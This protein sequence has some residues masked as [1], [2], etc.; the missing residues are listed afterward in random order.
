MPLLKRPARIAGRG[1][2]AQ[3][4]ATTAASV[5]YCSVF[6]FSSWPADS[7]RMPRRPP[8]RSS[9]GRRRTQNA[10]AH[11]AGNVALAISEVHLGALIHA[12]A[13]F[14][15]PS[16]SLPVREAA[17]L[18]YEYG[19]DL[20]APSYAYAAWCSWLLGYPDQAL[21]L[22]DEALVI[23]ERMQHAYTRSRGLYWNSAFHAF[24]GEWPIVAAAR[25][26]GDRLSGRKRTCDGR[27]G[28][29]DHAGG[30]A[31]DAGPA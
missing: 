28:G 25:R 1:S 15:G 6:G 30:G 19:V 20:G 18:T 27:G 17:R 31:S 8:T 21:R 2:C 29:S 9:S 16:G 14:E 26:G 13:H 4:S 5:P 10:G 12:R 11:I 24:R 7:T 22:G 3:R 23:P